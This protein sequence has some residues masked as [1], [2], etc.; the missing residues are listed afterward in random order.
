M[1]ALG[2]NLPGQL[3]WLLIAAYVALFGGGSAVIA[4][5]KGLDAFL[6]FI[7]GAVL[8]IIGLVIVLI[9]PGKQAEGS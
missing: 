3:G 7:L 9:I 2:I 1:E 5:R 6:G 8:G 4:R